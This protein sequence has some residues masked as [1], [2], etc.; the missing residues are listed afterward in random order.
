MD[1][2]NFE[3]Y[4]VDNKNEFDTLEPSNLIWEGIEKIEPQKKKRRFVLQQ[5][6]WI[7]RVAAAVVIFIASYYFHD[8]RYNQ[9]QIANNEEAL[10][11]NELYNSFIEAK[12]YYTAQI[13]AE[14][15]KFYNMAAD[16]SL[17]RNEIQNEFIE[18]DKEFNE[19]KEDL[20][21][22]ADNEEIIAAMIKNYRLKLSI[23]NEIMSEMQQVKTTKNTNNEN[24]LI[25]I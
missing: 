5:F 6:N 15:V 14:T 19:L 20:K 17:L 11:N 18:L 8:Y 7:T 22:N 2:D 9:K 12:F 24:N 23:L 4:I 3:K 21:D 25:Q 1:N 13:D 16:N 10:D